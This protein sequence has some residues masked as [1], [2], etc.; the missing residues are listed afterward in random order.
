MADLVT[1]AEFKQFLGAEAPADQDDL[2]SFLLDSFEELFEATCGRHDRPF[3]AAQTDRVEIHDG[4][5]SPLL[6]LD[7]PIE[8]VSAIVIGADPLAPDETLDPDDVAVVTWRAGRHRL[9]RVDGG[10]WGCQGAPNVVRVT[11]TTQDD[12][13]ARASLAIKRV[14]AGTWRQQGA[15]ELTAERTSTFSREFRKVADEDS[16][17]QLAVAGLRE[18]SFV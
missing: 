2:L 3:Q 18:R 4:T 11:Y 1:L 15:E 9:A 7:Y 6:F 12:L 14:A 5:R 8:T 10:T 13:P 17:W 16:I